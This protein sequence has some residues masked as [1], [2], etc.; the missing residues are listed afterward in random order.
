MTLRDQITRHLAQ[1]PGQRCTAA[2]IAAG[3]GA[4]PDAVQAELH[5]MDD[6]G[7]VLMRC[8]LYRLSEAAKRRA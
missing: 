1:M 7:E 4:D 2:E 3:I 6:A 5:A 8:G